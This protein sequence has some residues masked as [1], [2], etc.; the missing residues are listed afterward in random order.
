MPADD[1]E[2]KLQQLKAL[3][4]PVAEGAARSVYPAYD[5]LH[6]A[7]GMSDAGGRAKDLLAPYSPIGADGGLTVPP[8]AADTGRAIS[9]MGNALGS[10]F[11]ASYAPQDVMPT[12]KDAALIAGLAMTGGIAVPKP[13]GSLGIFG[14]KFPEGVTTER[15]LNP[16]SESPK[17]YDYNIKHDGRGIGQAMVADD[18]KNLTVHEIDV[19]KKYQGQGIGT[20]L[21]GQIEQDFGRELNPSN[22]LLKPGYQFWKKHYPDKVAD[23]VWDEA[24][25]AYVPNPKSRWTQDLGD[26]DSLDNNTLFS[27]PK[28][29]A[30]VGMVAAEGQGS[31]ATARAYRGMP[32]SQSWPPKPA[33]TNYDTFWASSDPSV[34]ETYTNPHRADAAPHVMPA[35]TRFQNPMV[36][37]AEG[38]SWNNVPYREKWY[39]PIK[40]RLST[41][42]L[43]D[44]ARERGHDGLV[45]NNVR[46]SGGTPPW[47]NQSADSPIATTYA[48]LKPGTVFSPLTGEQLFANPK[49]AA[50]LGLLASGG[51]ENAPIRAYHGTNESFDTFDPSK[52]KE[53]GF[54]FGSKETADARSVAKN[55]PLALPWPLGKGWNTIPVDINAQKIADLS[56]DPAGF[57]G[58]VLAKQLV[59]DGIAPPE[60]LKEATRLHVRDYGSGDLSASRD[61]V[62]NWLTS[63]GYDAVRYPNSYEGGGSS[64]MTMGTGNVTHAKTGKTLFSNAPEA[65]AA[66]TVPA[67]GDDFD[68]KL[69]QLRAH[70][71][72]AKLSDL[73]A[74]LSK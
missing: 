38:R 34:A 49:E 7:I 4:A 57:G 72:D 61:Y 11:G 68:S 9:K 65:A 15:V 14:G 24:N 41:D 8:A 27:N 6:A 55:G 67:A 5:A 17:F 71:F 12:N 23:Y 18:G 26:L 59:D 28:E 39:A 70:S 31:Q 45:V 44:I 53:V 3:L 2:A 20:A 66:G 10:A 51:S 74:H 46:D 21:Y 63:N 40:S 56:H 33:D 22:M 16:Y 62:R 1:F 13:V 50:P 19:D 47:A 36:V 64:Y 54:H 35:E 29:A 60:V 52:T 42:N 48:A 58:Y 25:K 30:P 73:K 43:A 32:D 69:A 37:D